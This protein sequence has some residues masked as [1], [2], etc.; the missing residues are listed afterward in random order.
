[1]EANKKYGLEGQQVA[2]VKPID[3]IILDLQMP[4]MNGIQII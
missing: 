4:K 2:V 1:M 3:I